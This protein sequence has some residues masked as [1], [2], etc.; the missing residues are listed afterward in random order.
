MGRD[1]LAINGQEGVP[2]VVCIAN[3]NANAVLRRW[4]GLDTDLYRRLARQRHAY[5]WQEVGFRR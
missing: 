2:S 4:P 1:Q 5:E 3:L